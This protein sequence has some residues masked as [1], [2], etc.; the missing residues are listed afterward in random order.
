MRA[1]PTHD[2]PFQAMPMFGGFPSKIS[3]TFCRP[4]VRQ[5][6]IQCSIELLAIG[7]STYAPRHPAPQVG[8]NGLRNPE[9]CR[10]KDCWEPGIW[11]VPDSVQCG[12]RAQGV[13]GRGK[14]WS[15]PSGKAVR[16]WQPGEVVRA[17]WADARTLK[18]F[19]ELWLRRRWS[20]V[21]QG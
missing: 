3:S 5:I 13:Q 2:G 20:S 11:D 12:T 21:S 16:M 1:A 9:A 19:S 4:E 10:G 18:H 7:L 17:L 8:G 6:S 14:L 15:V